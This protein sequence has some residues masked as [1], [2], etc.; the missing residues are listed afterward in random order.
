MEAD[1]QQAEVAASVRGLRWA[2]QRDRWF[3]VSASVAL[4]VM[5]IACVALSTEGSMLGALGL[6]G[7]L[8]G[9]YALN[10]PSG[11]TLRELPS[12]HAAMDA[13]SIQGQAGDVP[14]QQAEGMLAAAM[15][16]WPLVSW[17]RLNLAH[18]L[19]S[20]RGVQGRSAEAAALAEAVLLE[21]QGSPR[22]SEVG[23]RLI[24][25]E[26][27][28]DL[29]DFAGAWPHL[30]G[31]HR[32]A[33]GASPAMQ[34]LLLQTRY[35]VGLGYTDAALQNVRA[36]LELTEL[37][38]VGACVMMH[39]LLAQAAEISQQRELAGWLWRRVA[40]MAS[41]EDT[42]AWQAG[43]ETLAQQYETRHTHT[44]WEAP[45]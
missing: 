12:V 28:L 20:L 34:R 9:W 33:L 42:A 30:M 35:E 4:L 19:A 37:M 11:R 39:G 43:V 10:A 6:I 41:P 17:M 38:P 3:R 31:L 13:A 45:R 14:R 1:P 32:G 2:L 7:A 8:V 29:G 15:S 25:A 26:A 40:V 27:R 44:A 22:V 24:A 18:R 36:K 5:L 21:A 23:L 16:R